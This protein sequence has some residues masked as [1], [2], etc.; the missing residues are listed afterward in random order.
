MKQLEIYKK[1]LRILGRA[2]VDTDKFGYAYWVDETY[3]FGALCILICALSRS[4]DEVATRFKRDSEKVLG[5]KLNDSKYWFTDIKEDEL[6]A[7]SEERRVGK[8][9]TER[10]R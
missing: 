5:N 6:K 1:A 2:E 10:S 4:S 9:A 7:R 8:A 3:V